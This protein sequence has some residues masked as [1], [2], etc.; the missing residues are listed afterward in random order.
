MSYTTVQ[1]DLLLTDDIST[2]LNDAT[3]APLLSS[4]S[5]L[6]MDEPTDKGDLEDEIPNGAAMDNH[7]PDISLVYLPPS[8]SNVLPV[9]YLWHQCVV[10]M[11]MKK[12]AEDGPF[13]IDYCNAQKAE[14][15]PLEPP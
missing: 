7:K 6:G 3:I 10:F 4:M 9:S 11:E 5:T 8:N 2:L 14:G 12:K 13:G 1:S 15:G